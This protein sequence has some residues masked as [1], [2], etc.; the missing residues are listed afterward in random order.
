[1]NFVL[2]CVTDYLKTEQILVVS[3][4]NKSEKINNSTQISHAVK[5]SVILVVMQTTLFSVETGSQVCNDC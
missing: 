5:F 3:L 1:M 2:T 4:Y